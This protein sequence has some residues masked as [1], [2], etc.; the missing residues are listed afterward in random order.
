MPDHIS[1]P[2]PDR[3][4]SALRH[5]AILCRHKGA[6][7]FAERGLTEACDRDAT[8][9]DIMSGEVADVAR[10]YAFNPV[11]HTADD[12]PGGVPIAIAR[13]CSPLE[14]ISPALRD[15]IETHAGLA[16]ARGLVVA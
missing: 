5:D 15:F 10:V 16:Y 1:D 8:I 11:E 3:L 6:R 12:A 14:P 2:R 4:P 7:F 9:R 13:R